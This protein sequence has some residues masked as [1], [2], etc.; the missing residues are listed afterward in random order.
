MLQLIRKMVEFI[1]YISELSIS[2]S[3]W[4][5]FSR[6]NFVDKK[7]TKASELQNASNTSQI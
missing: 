1:P 2:F 6:I 5:D 4:R 3:P 7:K